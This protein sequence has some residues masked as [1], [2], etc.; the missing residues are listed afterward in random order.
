MKMRLVVMAVLALGG[1]VIG[2][3]S[4]SGPAT[5]PFSPFGN[6]PSNASAEPAGG[7]IETPA[8]SSGGGQSIEQLCATDCARVAAA[9]PTSTS[10]T[11]VSSCAAEINAYPSCTSQL[12]AFL[13][14]YATATISCMASYGASASG[15]TATEQSLVS[16][17]SPGS[18]VSTG[19]TP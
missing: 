15:C 7:S 16:C 8:G 10:S 9:C 18:M 17:I 6:D 19:G 12:R 2:C 14:C 3:G 4:G 1:A 13:E 5:P 11:C